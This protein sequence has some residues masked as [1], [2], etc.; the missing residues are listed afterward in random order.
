[1]E[2]EGSLPCSQCSTSVPY[3][4][5]VKSVLRYH[6]TSVLILFVLHF[7]LSHGNFFLMKTTFLI[8]RALYISARLI[9][10][11]LITLTVIDEKYSLRS[12]LV[13]GFLHPTITS[14]S[15]FKIFPSA[16]CSQTPSVCVFM[17]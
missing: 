5:P 7:V 8:S 4:Y 1:M 13:F 9:L 14:L 2:L 16:V 11:V 12:S 17:G 15:S 3:P 10:H 6:A